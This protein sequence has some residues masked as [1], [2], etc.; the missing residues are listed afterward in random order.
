MNK[1]ICFIFGAGT[2][3]G[4]ERADAENGFIIAA[5]GG[6]E[7]LKEL[8]LTPDLI[9]GDFDS[10]KEHSGKNVIKLPKIKDDTDTVAAVKEALK[11]GYKK[12]VIFG[13]TGGRE[14][15][16]L[17]NIQ[18]LSYI[19]HHGGTG[20]MTA[21]KEF[22]TVCN[23]K[24]VF[25]ADFKGFVSVFALS[26]KAVISEKGLKYELNKKAVTPHFPL[27]VSN[28]FTGTSAEITVHSGEVVIVTDK[29]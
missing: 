11:R 7:K 5:D 14:A 17:A 20:V 1:K 6:A 12:I 21:E 2:Y 27:G 15:H 9:I 22:I 4:D 10:G 29:Q 25:S 26:D 16:T 28:E 8:S 13:G 24:A 18:T 23:T 19:C 3:Y